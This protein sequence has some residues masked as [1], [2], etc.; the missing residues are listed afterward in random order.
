MDLT[1]VVGTFGAEKWARFARERAIP[2]AEAEGVEVIHHHGEMLDTYGSSLADCRNQAIEQAASEWICVLDA[3]DELRPG[4]VA[5]MEAASGDLRTPAVE[6]VRSGQVREPMFWPERPLTENNW[7][8]VSTL[9][10][11]QMFLDV[12]GYRDVPMYE[13]WDLFQRMVCAGATI[14]KVPAAICRVHI[15]LGSVHRNGSTRA[16]KVAAREHVLRLNHP[17]LFAA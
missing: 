5:A 17:E 12:G 15:N 7:M 3:D 8:I 4:Y 11:R 16:E 9:F 6:Y 14:E 2:S 10:R 1:V 13:D